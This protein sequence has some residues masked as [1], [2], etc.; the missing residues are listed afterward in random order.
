MDWICQGCGKTHKGGV[1]YFAGPQTENGNLYCAE[2]HPLKVWDS[3]DHIRKALYDAARQAGYSITPF[4]KDVSFQRWVT[5]TPCL[6]VWEPTVDQGWSYLYGKDRPRK[7]YLRKYTSPI[8]QVW[9]RLAVRMAQLDPT[10]KFVFINEHRRLQYEVY[11]L[12]E[13]VE[14]RLPH[15]DMGGE[16]TWVTKDGKTRLCIDVD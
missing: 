3:P 13:Y 2:T 8:S 7:D 10:M 11:D 14:I 15:H 4:I 16:K 6:G 1:P 12:G 9:M 5:S